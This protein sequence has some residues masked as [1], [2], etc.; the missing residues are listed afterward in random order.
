[1]GQ[2]RMNTIQILSGGGLNIL[3]NLTLAQTLTHAG[4]AT[5]YGDMTV[6]DE[7]LAPH[8]RDVNDTGFLLDPSAT[9]R[10]RDFELAE[11][12]VSSGPVSFASDLISQGTFYG[13]Q[14]LE[15]LSNTTVGHFIYRRA[16]AIENGTTRP[17]SVDE[18]GH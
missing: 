2:S 9:T 16:L 18:T 11:S 10:L 5:F 1:S 3:G 6:L 7:V 12:L 8:I 17:F 13:N 14:S 15:A 4:S